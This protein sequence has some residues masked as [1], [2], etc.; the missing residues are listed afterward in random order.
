MLFGINILPQ[1]S[2]LKLHTALTSGA[3]DVPQTGQSP[4]LQQCSKH[5]T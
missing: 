1:T 4:S 3:K 5:S 2:A